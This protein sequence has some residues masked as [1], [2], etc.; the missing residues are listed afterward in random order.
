MVDGSK[1]ERRLYVY[2][3]CINGIRLAG[4][5]LPFAMKYRI[6]KDSLGS[7][8]VPGDAFYGVQTARALSNFPVSGE[9]NHP[10]LIRA[11]AV[12][13]K[14]CAATNHELGAL[15]AKRAKAIVRACDGI[16]AGGRADQFV[17][18]RYQA[19][20]GTSL[21]MNVN[22]VIANMALESLG[23]KKGDYARL[24][25][26]DH[27]NMSQSTNDTFPT[28]AHIALGLDIQQLIG[29]LGRLESSL[30]KKA[31]E[32]APLLKSGRTHL[33]DAVPVTLGQEF[34]AYASS[35]KKSIALL[36]AVTGRGYGPTL[37]EV[38]IGGTAVGTGIN[39]PPHYRATVIRHLRVL[40]GLKLFASRDPREGLQ[41]RIALSHTSGILNTIAL[42]L[43]RI[44]ND[45]RL[46]SS[47][48]VTGLAEIA[49]PAV[50]PG[51]SI[52]PGKANPVMAEALDMI[53]FRVAGNSLT[54]SMAEQAGQLELNVMMPL[55]ANTLLE[56]VDILKNFLPVFAEKAIDGITVNRE[57][58]RYYFEHTPAIAT[59]LNPV[60]GYLNAAEVVKQA[61]REGRPVTDIILE[62]GF[63][64]RGQLKKLLSPRSIAGT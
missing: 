11:Y 58:L 34:S 1:G 50:Q 7:M 33:Q 47:G 14:A 4:P 6:E 42:E 28:V 49:L 54:V 41:S 18:D 2:N 52:M 9:R 8:T 20:A 10:S 61:I 62:K 22:E 38:P 60:I 3:H 26:N 23:H 30:L 63:L 27:V 17:I 53:C 56:S 57:R 39:T 51:S 64:T 40:T 24:S 43:I 45:L 36:G 21:N 35:I 59:L 5:Y 19:G 16:L 48:P 31:G 32:Y 25:P 44:A 29:A 15:D 12:V 46:L 37:L 55:M 13:K